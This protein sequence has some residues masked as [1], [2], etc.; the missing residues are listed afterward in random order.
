MIDRGAAT[1]DDVARLRLTQ[2]GFLLLERLRTLENLAPR[3][4]CVTSAAASLLAV[5]SAVM[6]EGL[7]QEP[8]TLASQLR[9]GPTLL[10]DDLHLSTLYEHF[11][12]LATFHPPGQTDLLS[13]SVLWLTYMAAEKA[14]S[15]ARREAEASALADVGTQL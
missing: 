7:E 15:D 3:I 8:T 11:S 1:V 13:P 14:E 6:R 5:P 12:A 4:P 2:S 10:L 9:D